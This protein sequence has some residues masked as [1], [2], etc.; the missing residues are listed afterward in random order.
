MLL[1]C[2]LFLLLFWVHNNGMHRRDCLKCNFLPFFI[3]KH[4]NKLK[5]I[6]SRFLRTVSKNIHSESDMLIQIS[7]LF[8]Y[9]KMCC[10]LTIFTLFQSVSRLISNRIYKC[11]SENSPSI[12]Y[13]QERR[14]SEL[15][16]CHWYPDC[17]CNHFSGYGCNFECSDCSGYVTCID[18]LKG[19]FESCK[20]QNEPSSKI[21][22]N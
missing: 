2:M 8:R 4:K 16:R 21:E 7:S 19:L 5:C 18:S 1:F 15:E 20:A 6:L 13:K 3:I 14:K 10:L 9:C 17:A 12:K 11:G 22:I